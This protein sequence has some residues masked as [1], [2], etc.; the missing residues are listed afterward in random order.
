MSV[1]SKKIITANDLYHGDVVF[2]VSPTEWSHEISA[3]TIFEAD[4][5]EAEKE[6]SIAEEQ[7]DK[8]VG[9]YITNV[10]IAPNG[11]VTPTHIRERI[12][13]A[14]VGDYCY[15]ASRRLSHVSL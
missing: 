13:A 14:G 2:W 3:A 11:V 6:L 7:V 5:V 12:R 1:F 15:P 4:D 9:V 8:V 10:S